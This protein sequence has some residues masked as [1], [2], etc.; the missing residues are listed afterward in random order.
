MSLQLGVCFC[1]EQCPHNYEDYCST[2]CARLDALNALVGRQNEELS[3]NDGPSRAASFVAGHDVK[4]LRMA[5]QR[6]TREY[7]GLTIEMHGDNEQARLSVRL[8]SRISGTLGSH[9]RDMRLLQDTERHNRK[10]RRSIALHAYDFAS[11]RLEREQQARCASE[12]HNDD[13]DDP[14]QLDFFCEY[15]GHEE[16]AKEDEQDDESVLNVLLSDLREGEQP[17]VET[18]QYARPVSQFSSLTESSSATWMS[19]V[20]DCYEDPVGWEGGRRVR[21]SNLLG[22]FQIAPESQGRQSTCEEGYDAPA[23]SVDAKHVTERCM[24]GAKKNPPPL[25]IPLDYSNQRRYIAEASSCA[26]TLLPPTPTSPARSFRRLMSS[27]SKTCST[28]FMRRPSKKN[29]RNG[30]SNQ[31]DD[32]GGMEKDKVEVDQLVTKLEALIASKWN[33]F[34][35]RKGGSSISCNNGSSSAAPKGRNRAYSS[36][37][38]AQHHPIL[39]TATPFARRHHRVNGSASL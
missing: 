24:T 34:M 21:S 32:G 19:P 13:I 38:P 10:L 11:A 9:Y 16:E 28:L 22:L 7:P 37:Q 30:I 20:L 33:P 12:A 36:H 15:N 18:G 14:C 29:L 4:A 5:S 35:P 17:A 39:A 27:P 31:D 23:P 2:T 25:L 6:L 26:S 8:S 3:V 1:G